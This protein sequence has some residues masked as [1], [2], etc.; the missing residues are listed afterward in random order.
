MC[1]VILRFKNYMYLYVRVRINN[2]TIYKYVTSYPT[3]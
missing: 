1:L 2:Y 3:F